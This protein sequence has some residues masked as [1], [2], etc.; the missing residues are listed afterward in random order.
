[1]SVINKL[2]ALNIVLPFTG[3]SWGKLFSIDYK[4]QNLQKEWAIIQSIV[5]TIDKT[6]YV[7]KKIM[8]KKGSSDY[9]LTIQD[10]WKAETIH[11]SDISMFKR[12][13]LSRLA[14]NDDETDIK[15]EERKEIFLRNDIIPNEKAKEK[16]LTCLDMVWNCIN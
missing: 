11:F 3:K 9:S 15:F 8:N 13:N 4:F 7:C 1:M 14:K 5:Y 12:E 2:L 6:R 16:I 10:T